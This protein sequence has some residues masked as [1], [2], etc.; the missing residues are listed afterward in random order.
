[1]PMRSL[2]D[3]F[4]CP[5]RALI[6]IIVVAFQ[7]IAMAEVGHDSSG[8]PEVGG[9]LLKQRSLP[10]TVDRKLP[11]CSAAGVPT[12]QRAPQITGHH[13]V[14]LSWNASAPRPRRYRLH[15]RPGGA[16]RR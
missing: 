1:M 9:Y 3:L 14:T 16:G 10:T 11:A 2:D 8:K 7:T 4:S 5:L 15:R 6:L 12:V 13:K